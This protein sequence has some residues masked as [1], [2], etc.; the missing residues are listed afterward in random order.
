MSCLFN[1]LAPAVS[2]GSSDLRRIIANYLKTNPKLLDDIKAADIIQWTEDQDLQVYANRMSNTN[3]WGGAIE[4]KAFCQLFHKNVVIHVLYTGKQFHV[5]S[6]HNST[7]NVHI[8]YNGT[9]FE[10]M[11]IEIC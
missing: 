6:S 7:C 3:T 2:I 8:S 10:P 5:K 9:H 1:S 4:I 11:Y